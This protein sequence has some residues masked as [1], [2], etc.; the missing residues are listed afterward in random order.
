MVLHL[1]LMPTNVNAGV[2]LSLL[3]LCYHERFGFLDDSVLLQRMWYIRAHVL[4]L[5]SPN[6]PRE[7]ERWKWYDH[8]L[9]MVIYSWVRH[10]RKYHVRSI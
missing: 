10:N 5:D 9:T 2:Q 4:Q 1:N 3:S 6:G 8:K 7:G